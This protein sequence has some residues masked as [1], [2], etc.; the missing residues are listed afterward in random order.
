MAYGHAE[1]NL[2]LIRQ[3]EAE[4]AQLLGDVAEPDP[5]QSAW[6]RDA[7]A[8]VSRA[9][10]ASASRSDSTASSAGSCSAVRA[11]ASGATTGR[12][13]TRLADRTFLRA[14]SLHVGLTLTQP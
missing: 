14:L 10:S 3:L 13:A 9:S 8:S 5:E 7:E 11:L 12:Q 1:R 4:T 2:A 6:L